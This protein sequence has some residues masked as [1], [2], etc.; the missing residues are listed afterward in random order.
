MP[1]HS[2][3]T[4]ATGHPESPSLGDRKWPHTEPGEN[5]RGY[6][7]EEKKPHCGRQPG[8]VR[9]R[10]PIRIPC[11]IPGSHT[12]LEVELQPP[13]QGQMQQSKT[14]PNA[15]QESGGGQLGP[16]TPYQ[17]RWILTGMVRPMVSYGSIVWAK[18]I[19]SSAKTRLAVKRLQRL[20]MITMGHFRKSTPTGRHGGHNGPPAT[21]PP[22]QTG[23]PGSPGQTW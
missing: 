16:P 22:H 6:L 23:V 1:P 3:G 4:D 13:H 21:R 17:M 15:P 19:D 11:K 20:A 8:D 10:D 14:V 7:Y 18:H 5:S 9:E 2:G 12:R